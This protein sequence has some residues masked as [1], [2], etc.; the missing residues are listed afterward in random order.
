MNIMTKGLQADIRTIHKNNKLYNFWPCLSMQ[1]NPH[2]LLRDGW[3]AWT[4]MPN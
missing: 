4:N 3:L 2:V 1:A